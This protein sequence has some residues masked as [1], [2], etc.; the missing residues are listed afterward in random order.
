MD[1]TATTDPQQQQQ[2]ESLSLCPWLPAVADKSV[3]LSSTACT[4]QHLDSMLHLAMIHSDN[5]TTRSSAMATHIRIQLLSHLDDIL[6]QQWLRRHVSTNLTTVAAA[7][8]WAFIVSHETAT[9]LAVR[10]LE[11]VTPVVQ[12]VLN[13]SSSNTTGGES[14]TETFGYLHLMDACVTSLLTAGRLDVIQDGV[15]S[16]AE[17]TLPMPLSQAYVESSFCMSVVWLRLGV[18]QLLMQAMQHVGDGNGGGY[19]HDG[20]M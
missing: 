1:T 3:S 17:F 10:V 8:V 15:E 16:L 14:T 20:G 11:E 5:D 6:L 9:E 18:Q 2:Q 19:H 13:G 7:R 4:P 12:D